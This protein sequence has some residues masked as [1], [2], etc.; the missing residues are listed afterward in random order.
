MATG[1]HRRKQSEAKPL[2]WCE[3]VLI[4]ST[5]YD[6]ACRNFEIYQH[7]A[8]GTYSLR[9]LSCWRYASALSVSSATIITVA[10]YVTRTI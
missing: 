5:R 8:S 1:V 10:C 3:P 7:S 4:V 2:E 9:R 6:S